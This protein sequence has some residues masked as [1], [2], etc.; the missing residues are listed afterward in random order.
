MVEGEGASLH[1]SPTISDFLRLRAGDG[2]PLVA[3]ASYGTSAS[4]WFHGGSLKRVSRA[5]DSLCS[6]ICIPSLSQSW[7]CRAAFARHPNFRAVEPPV[8]GCRVGKQGQGPRKG[9][10]ARWQRHE[11]RGPS[12]RLRFTP[13]GW[14]WCCIDTMMNC[15]AASG[16]KRIRNMAGIQVRSRDIGLEKQ[17]R[18]T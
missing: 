8:T 11:P 10:D 9:G 17:G 13:R 12:R 5:S 15:L 3:E 16:S 7:S 18:I 6:T 2:N 4:S 1:C 14:D